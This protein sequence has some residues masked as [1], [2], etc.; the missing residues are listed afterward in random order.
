[1]ADL[2]MFNL[3]EA[4]RAQRALRDSLGLEE[5]VFP[6]EAFVE[7][8]S[9]EIEQMRAAGRPDSDIV[10]IVAQTTGQQMTASDIA[11]HYIAPEHRHGGGRG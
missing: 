11:T 2:A 6:V 4:I 3:E 7:M 8:I 10:A 5:E 1:M 9:D